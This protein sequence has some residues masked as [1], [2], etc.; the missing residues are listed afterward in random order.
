LYNMS[1][2]N[3]TDYSEFCLGTGVPRHKDGVVGPYVCTYVFNESFGIS[4]HHT[5]VVKE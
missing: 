2:A 3:N 1:G 4:I 5:V